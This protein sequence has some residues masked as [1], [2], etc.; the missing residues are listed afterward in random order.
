MQAT[1]YTFK[2]KSRSVKKYN[3]IKS[4][5]QKKKYL[6]YHETKKKNQKRPKT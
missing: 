6:R 2:V 4:E 1:S 3:S 5:K